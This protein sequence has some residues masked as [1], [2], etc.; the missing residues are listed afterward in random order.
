MIRAGSQHSK[1]VHSNGKKFTTAGAE[2]NKIG[3]NAFSTSEIQNC[4]K[5]VRFN[6]RGY[7]KNIR[8]SMLH[9]LSEW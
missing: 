4:T 2:R 5:P 1:R 7:G 9:H 3:A 8:N 6:V